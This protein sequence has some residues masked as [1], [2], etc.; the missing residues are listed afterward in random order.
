MEQ[1][2]KE[3][4]EQQ[5]IL[6]KIVTQVVNYQITERI[7]K[8]VETN[9]DITVK[10]HEAGNLS[11]LKQEMNHL[12]DTEVSEKVERGLEK[13]CRDDFKII[14]EKSEYELNKELFSLYKEIIAEAGKL[15]KK[16]GYMQIV[17]EFENGAHGFL[18]RIG[19]GPEPDNEELLK[20][21][22]E[23]I[24]LCRKYIKAMD[25]SRDLSRAAI[26]KKALKLWEE[27]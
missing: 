2:K 10:L 4:Q 11:D 6:I 22:K 27:A 25:E 14:R 13:F 17:G 3:L 18:T 12:V 1:C 5:E 9:G 21:Q 23:W 7:S 15:L 16:Y 8:T 26:E 24:I 19:M 20:E